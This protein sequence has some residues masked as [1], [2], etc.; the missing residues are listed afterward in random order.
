MA[1]QSGGVRGYGASLRFSAPKFTVNQTLSKRLLQQSVNGLQPATQLRLFCVCRLGV[2]SSTCSPECSRCQLASSL[3]SG[4]NIRRLTNQ[5]T[6]SHT[7]TLIDQNKQTQMEFNTE[8]TRTLPRGREF[9]PDSNWA[10]ISQW[11][12]EVTD[13]ERMLF[14]A[15]FTQNVSA[16]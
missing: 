2:K 3:N 11:R 1:L 4:G 10:F 15:S 13:V 9:F 5:Q 14:S 16:E 6:A 12:S 8:T 7:H